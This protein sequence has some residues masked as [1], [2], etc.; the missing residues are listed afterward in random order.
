[1]RPLEPQLTFRQNLDSYGSLLVRAIKASFAYRGSTVTAVLTA[2]VIYAVPMFVWRQVYVQNPGNM[3]IPKAKMFPYLLLACCVNYALSVG[4]EWRIG[5][6]IRS[7]LIA[8]DLLK[9]TDLQLSQAIQCLSDA[10]FNGMLGLIVFF[11]GYLILGREVLPAGPASFGLFLVSFL[12]A[13]FVMFGICF[14]FVQGIFY[15]YAFYGIMTARGAL[16]LTFSG[17]SAPLMA[18]P[19]LLKTVAGWLPFQHTIFTPVSIYM[20]WVRGADAFKL[21]LEQAAW[22]AILFL[23]GRFLMS[24]SLKQLEVQGG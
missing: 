17:L 9:P 8:T 19:P 6:R 18:Y 3:F 13:F 16:H 5:S 24:R 4:I 11:C 21:I 15:T 10:I 7:G 2:T 14:I 22:V 1:M 20:G 23:V 12:L